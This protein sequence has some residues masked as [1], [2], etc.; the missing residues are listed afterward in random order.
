MVF[1]YYFRYFQALKKIQRNNEQK[2]ELCINDETMQYW[3]RTQ[4]IKLY[5]NAYFEKADS[6]SEEG[7]LKKWQELLLNFDS[8]DVFIFLQ[9]F[10]IFQFY[11]EMMFCL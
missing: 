2:W 10:M 8:Q 6:N 11:I 1:L 3:D 7:L 5:L 9:E 4:N